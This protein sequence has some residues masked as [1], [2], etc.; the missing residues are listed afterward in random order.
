MLLPPRVGDPGRVLLG[1]GRQADACIRVVGVVAPLALEGADA[2]RVEE[3]REFRVGHLVALDPVGAQVDAV[4][5]ALL[6]GAVV[7]AHPERASL[8]EHDAVGK[9]RGRPARVSTAAIPSTSQRGISAVCNTHPRSNTP[10]RA[11]VSWG[12][13][14]DR[15]M[16][17]NP[18]KLATIGMALVGTTALGHWADHLVHDADARSRRGA[19]DCG[20][21]ASARQRARATAGPRGPVATHPVTRAVAPAAPPR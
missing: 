3:R 11:P 21:H 17:C 20:V 5:R 7:A 13:R 10:G 12:D 4:P 1:G 2:A 15:A 6:G 16:E 8:H 19:G 18:W 9:G 14:E